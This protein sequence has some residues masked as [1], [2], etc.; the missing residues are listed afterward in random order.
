[1]FPLTGIEYDPPASGPKP[2][3]YNDSGTPPAGLL[4]W[5]CCLLRSGVNC[6]CCLD[7]RGRIEGVFG[8]GVDISLQMKSLYTF[9]LKSFVIH[10]PSYIHF[11]LS[12]YSDTN[13]F[14]FC[15]N[16]PTKDTYKLKAHSRNRVCPSI[17]LFQYK[18]RSMDYDKILY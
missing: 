9:A 4:G 14:K 13:S 18:N 6:R 11:H 3:H 12:H 10:V 17:R 8:Q 5:L 2:S 16:L 7:L 1:M 15:Y